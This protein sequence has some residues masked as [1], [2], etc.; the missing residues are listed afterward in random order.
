MSHPVFLSLVVILVALAYAIPAAAQDSSGRGQGLQAT[1]L[2]GATFSTLHGA[3][4][5]DRRTGTMGGVSLLFPFAGPLSLQPEL[6]FVSR[7]AKSAS[8]LREGLEI[9]SVQ[10]PA[11]LRL[12]LTPRSDLTPHLYA[13]PYLAFELD[14]SVEG[15]NLDCDEFGT[16]DTNAVDVG[17][18]AGGGVSFLAGPLLLTGGMRYDFG[19]SSLAEFESGSVRESARHGAFALYVGAG[20]RIGG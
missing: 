12:S 8:E 20:I 7:G 4:D 5:L 11:L 15:S 1:V 17:G 13:G 9:S 2:A 14:C 18:I 19:I 3:D 10:L 16:V 6:L